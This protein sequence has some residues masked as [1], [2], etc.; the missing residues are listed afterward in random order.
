MQR[1]ELIFNFFEI[2]VNRLEVEGR[3]AVARLANLYAAE[4]DL[5]ANEKSEDAIADLPF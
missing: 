2:A 4:H 5:S 3:F 1:I